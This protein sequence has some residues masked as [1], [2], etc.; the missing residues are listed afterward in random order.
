MSDGSGLAEA[1]LG[2]DGFR[3]LDAVETPAELVLTIETDAD[4]GVV[5]RVV[6]AEAHNLMPVE[7]PPISGVLEAG[8]VGVVHAPVALRRS[9]V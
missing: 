3:V 4:L 7:I 2:L 8:T 6:R 9:G 1:L 5:R